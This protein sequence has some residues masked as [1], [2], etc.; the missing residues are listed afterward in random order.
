MKNT[1]NIFNDGGIF[2]YSGIADDIIKYVE[3]VQLK[4]RSIWNMITDQFSGNPDDVDNGWR[5]EYWGKLMRGAAVVYKY[6]QDDE[7]YSIL[8]DATVKLIEKIDEYG[9]IATYSIGHEFCGWDMWGRKY[10]L[11]GLIHFID[12]CKDRE[13]RAKVISA[14]CSH[15]DYIISKIGHGKVEI[16]DTSDM[17]GG[18]NS[19]SILEPVVRLYNLTGNDKY[20]EFASYIVECGGAKN[21]NIFEAAYEDKLYPYEYPVLKAYEL[22]SCFE[23]LLEYYKVTGI[24]KWK[25]AVINFANKLIESEITI[26][27]SAGCKHELFNHSRLMQTYSG[28][29]GLMQ[30]TCVTVTWIKLCFRLLKLTGKALYA[31]E[32]EKS[33]YNAL[34]GSVNTEG[35]VCGQEATFDEDYYRDVYDTYHKS[36]HAGQVFDSYSPL[37]SDIRGK[38]VG[39]FKPMYDNTAY[40]GCCIAIGAIGV[41]LVPHMSV[42]KNE[43]GFSFMLYLPG[44]A[45][46]ETADG[47][48]VAFN[49]VTCYPSDNKINITVNTDKSSEFELSLRVPYF[50]KS[51][52]VKING[53]S[54]ECENKNG[55]VSVNKLWNDGDTVSLTLD[56]NT[57][58]MHGEYNP[59]DELSDKYIAIMHGPVVLARDARIDK[60]GTELHVNCDNVSFTEEEFG[61]K[62]ILSGK[63]EVD[64]IKLNMIDYASAGKT[65][66]HDSETEVWIKNTA[67]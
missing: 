14:A 33:V 5:C 40:F 27:G 62:S 54:I 37:H 28:Y 4:D 8:S 15:L 41:G 51:F 52:D 65:W 25:D 31:D 39:G 55:T 48:K 50:S 11:L 58:I 23:G 34:Y 43:K 18:I 19:S 1:K 63:V 3:R 47:N 66:C 36:H 57:R 35:C 45:L 67:D 12:I 16:T 61:I 9:R 20:I 53:E 7:L 46:F 13:L 22:M 32:I 26:I 2:N 21:F 30:E 64:G 44:R 56:M 38:A 17:W 6:T 42:L 60:P 29:N 10:V 59:E 24:E 49:I